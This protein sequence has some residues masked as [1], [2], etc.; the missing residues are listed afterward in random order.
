MGAG[1]WLIPRFP[2][3][4]EPKRYNNGLVDDAG[5]YG[6]WFLYSYLCNSVPVFIV[7]VALRLAAVS[8][9]Q[10][11]SK[12]IAKISRCHCSLLRQVHLAPLSSSSRLVVIVDDNAYGNSS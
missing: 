7:V 5:A 1:S 3:I 6:K 12:P 10:G 11:V 8:Y 2:T 4:L 9:D